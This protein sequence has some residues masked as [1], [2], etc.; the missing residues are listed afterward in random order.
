MAD[1]DAVFIGSG[2][3]CSFFLRKRLE[4]LPGRGRYLVL[5]R[6]PMVPHDKQVADR[7][8]SPFEPEETYRLETQPRDGFT[9]RWIFNIGFGGGSNCWWAGTPRMLPV[10][11]EMQTRYGVGQ[12]WPLSYTDLE[13]YYAEIEQV[14]QVAGSEDSPFPNRPPYPLP[15][16]RMTDPDR[17]LKAAWPDLYFSQPTARASRPTGNRNKCCANGTCHICPI[18]AKFTILNGMADTYADPRVT[19]KTEAEVLSIDVEAGIARGVIY[20]EGGKEHRVTAETVVLGANAIFNPYLLQ[21][22]GLDGDLVGRGL[23]EQGSVRALIY[24]DG[25]EGMNGSTSV[26]GH[27]YMLY[28]GEHR[29]DTGAALIEGWNVPRLRLD[30][31]RWTQLTEL[32]IVIEDLPQAENRVL[33]DPS[34]ETRPLIRY[35]GQSEYFYRGLDRVKQRL[36]DVLAAL[37]VERIE[38]LPLNQTEAHTQGTT[39]FGTDPA[40]SVVDRELIHHQVR[41]LYVVGNSVF[42]TGSPANPT[43]TTAALVTRSAGLM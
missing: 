16:H 9:K 30:Y 28:D 40:T 43:L 27:G 25:M 37:P 15:S 10:D 8:S 23:H 31:D 33:V 17:A 24:L 39:P 22:S 3:A 38:Y 2:F 6:G 14:M 41:N 1:F 35:G 32:Y 26:T 34:D 5:E 18:D 29:R 36:P 11:F 21:R 20:R 13:P 12:D 19:L 42:P 4:K 7:N